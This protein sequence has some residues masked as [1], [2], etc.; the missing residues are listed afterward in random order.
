MASNLNQVCIEGNLVRNPE[1]RSTP[2]G[3]PVLNFSIASNR[4]RKVGDEFE[5]ETSYFDVQCWDRLA[6]DVYAFGKKGT[7]VKV[8][9]R[10]KQ[11]R[12]TGRDGKNASKI[13]IVA[14]TVNK[15]ERQPREHQ[16]DY[17]QI[18]EHQETGGCP[19]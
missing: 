17:P 19:F 16:E 12:W 10:L 7:P 3:M 8:T 15:Q 6:E 5:K 9:G 18:Q 2:R 11:D 1:M 14:E 13:I 4:Y